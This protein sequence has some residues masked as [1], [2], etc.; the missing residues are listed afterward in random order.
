MPGRTSTSG[1]TIEKFTGKERDESIGLDYFGARYYDPAIGRWHNPDPRSDKFPGLTPYNYIANNPILASDPDG[2]DFTIDIQRD[3]D[4][5]ITGL[6]FTANIFTGDQ[7]SFEAAQTA[8]ELWNNAGGGSAEIEGLVKRIFGNNTEVDINVKVNVFNSGS[9]RAAKSAA[10]GDDAGNFFEIT[11]EADFEERYVNRLRG[12][13]DPAK[14]GGI[15]SRNQIAL[16]PNQRQ[17]Q[18]ANLVGR[19]AHEIGH[20]FRLRDPSTGSGGSGIMGY[21]SGNSASALS[22]I[23]AVSVGDVSKLGRRNRRMDR[24]HPGASLVRFKKLK[25]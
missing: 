24:R 17:G 9:K 6:I 19:A 21:P 5:N 4:G 18:N 15:V 11:G 25:N 3:E 8:A 14:V 16:L 22:N 10:T 7:Q 20:F 1:N 12:D 13:N 2:Q 23:P